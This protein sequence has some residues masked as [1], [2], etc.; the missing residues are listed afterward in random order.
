MSNANKEQN[1]KL[2]QLV[3]DA[4]QHD[5]E[6]RDKHQIGDKFRF[7]R[8][9]L[10]ALLLNV[11]ESVNEIAQS[12][13]PI[14][15]QMSEDEVLVYVYLYNAQ[16]MTFST[17]QKMLIPSVFYEYSVNRPVYTEHA[18][19]Q[20]F[21]RSR[22]NKQQH[23]YLTIAVKKQ[24][25]LPAAEGEVAQDSHGNPLVKVREGALRFDRLFTFTHNERQYTVNAEGEVVKKLE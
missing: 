23:A 3:R 1:E 11:E 24:D 20:A 25:I 12:S 17:W 18:H 6:L 14:T 8:D 16:G 22:T 5:K 7:I 19:I 9:R 10:N 2:L 13:A 15:R 4:V 21:L